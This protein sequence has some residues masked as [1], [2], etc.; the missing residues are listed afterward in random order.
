[1]GADVSDLI[2]GDSSERTWNDGL[3][4][5]NFRSGVIGFGVDG[6]SSDQ[7]ASI[8][9]YDTTGVDISSQLEMDPN[10]LLVIPEPTTVSLLV[11]SFGVLV[12]VRRSRY[13]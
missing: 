3:T 13:F 5:T 10:G 12:A 6:L 8:T 4:I 9:I 2:F 11:L 7:L 1:L